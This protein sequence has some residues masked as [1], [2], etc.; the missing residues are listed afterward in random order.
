MRWSGR[1]SSTKRSPPS[2]CA[3]PRHVRPSGSSRCRRS[4]SDGETMLMA[5]SRI[6]FARSPGTAVEP[7]CSIAARS[8]A[9]AS[10]AASG[11]NA[12]AQRGSPSASTTSPRSRPSVASSCSTRPSMPRNGSG[13]VA[14]PAPTN[15]CLLFLRA[16]ALERA[17]DAGRRHRRLADAKARGVEEGVRDRRG[18]RRQ[19]RLTRAG[20]ARAGARRVRHVGAAEAV[21]VHRRGVLEA[22]HRIGDPVEAGHTALVEDDRLVERTARGPASRRL[23]RCSRS[24]PGRR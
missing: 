11:A 19:R 13:P 14:G 8:S 6:G 23:P 9:R 12:S 21:D 3:S 24:R 18:H 15:R 16:G 7:T 17:A 2:L 20:S 1:S 10:S 22:D 4:S 5:T